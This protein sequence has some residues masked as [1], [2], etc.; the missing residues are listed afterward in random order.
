[1]FLGSEPRMEHLSA[2]S[3]ADVAD[4]FCLVLA[5]HTTYHDRGPMAVNGIGC[6]SHDASDD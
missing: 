3:V 4:Y 1:M 6:S 2:A 5:M